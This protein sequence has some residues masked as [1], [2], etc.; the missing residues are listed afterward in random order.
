[1]TAYEALTHLRKARNINP[2][3]QQL[4]YVAKLHNKTFGYEVNEDDD[5]SPVSY[6]RSLITKNPGKI[7]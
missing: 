3:K 1:M 5:Q 6:V 4:L 7:K 2:S